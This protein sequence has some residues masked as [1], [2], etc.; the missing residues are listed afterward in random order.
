VTPDPFDGAAVFDGR[1]SSYKE[2]VV[3]AMFAIGDWFLR[4]VST[5]GRGV[6]KLFGWFLQ[7]PWWKK[8][9]VML[10]SL[11]AML[12]AVFGFALAIYLLAPSLARHTV[13]PNMSARSSPQQT[14]VTA[15]KPAATP[16]KGATVVAE[17]AYA[18]SQ[19]LEQITCARLRPIQQRQDVINTY[20]AASVRRKV[21]HILNATAKYWWSAGL[22][23]SSANEA[24]RR[25]TEC[26]F[27]NQS[28]RVHTLRHGQRLT[29]DVIADAELPGMNTQ[30]QAV[31]VDLVYAQTVTM[32]RQGGYWYYVASRPIPNAPLSLKR[33]D[34]AAFERDYGFRRRP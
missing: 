26:Q 22:G 11:V 32:Q 8:L 1:P 20:V 24:E 12:V 17:G 31:R 9:L 28:Y 23:L 16:S 25:S 18:A 5:A 4:C 2:V 10:G 6:I 19:A 29:I 33:S 7:L 34:F 15:V 14:T 30:S 3:P 13:K 27:K 21:L